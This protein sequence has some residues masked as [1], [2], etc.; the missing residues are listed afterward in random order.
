MKKWAKPVVILVV[1]S[2]LV[3][4]LVWGVKSQHPVLMHDKVHVSKLDA[5]EDYMKLNVIGNLSD[6]SPVIAQALKDCD[7]PCCYDPTIPD[8]KRVLLCGHLNSAEYLEE[9]LLDFCRTDVWA[10]SSCD[11]FNE[12]IKYSICTIPNSELIIAQ[13]Y[14]ISCHGKR[15]LKL[16][17]D[18]LPTCPM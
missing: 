17:C 12:R 15:I 6:V 18:H 16:D 13:F 14:V 1:F 10:F 4:L 8:G 2:I 9:L 5:L 7:V 11:K 3:G